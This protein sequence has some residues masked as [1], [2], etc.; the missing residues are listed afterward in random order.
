M[1]DAPDEFMDRAIKNLRSCV[2]HVRVVAWGQ[3]TSSYE[4]EDDKGCGG[5]FVRRV[6]ITIRTLRRT[7]D[8]A[9]A[10][11]PLGWWAALGKWGPFA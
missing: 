5:D 6:D 4:L 7:D 11:K 2:D 3:A 8:P 9:P 10:P 1:T